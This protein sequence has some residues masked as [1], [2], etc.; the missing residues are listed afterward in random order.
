MLASGYVRNS[1]Q[2]GIVAPR[3]SG[4]TSVRTRPS[5]ANRELVAWPRSRWWWT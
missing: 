4:P 1:V 2:H 5:R 3:E